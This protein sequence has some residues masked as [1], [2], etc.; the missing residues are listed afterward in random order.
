MKFL[1]SWLEKYIELSDLQDNDLAKIITTKSSEVEEI[2]LIDDYFGGKVLVGRIENS[3]KHPN[4]D[5]LTIFDVNLGGSKTVQIISAA[6]NVKDGL[7]V[8]VA[9]E[10]AVL[11]D[12]TIIKRNMRGEISEGMSCGKSELFQETGFSD[13]LWELNNLLSDRKEREYLGISI[14]KVFSDLFP[15]ETIFDI[16]VLPDRIGVIANHLGMALEINSCLADT[17]RLTEKAKRLTDSNFDIIKEV[18]RNISKEDYIQGEFKDSTGYSNSFWLFSLDLKQ[19]NPGDYHLPHDLKKD[20]FLLEMNLVGGLADLSNYLLRDMG[21]PSH[22]F[23]RRKLSHLAFGEHSD[24]SKEILPLKWNVQELQFS[25]T[26]EGLGQ[27]KKVE[28]P[29]GVRVLKNEKGQTLAVPAISGGKS[30][31][32]DSEDDR[33]VVEIAN[34]PAEEVA[35]NSFRLKYRSDGSKIWAGQVN[36]RQKLIFLLHLLEILGDEVSLKYIYFWF[37]P[38]VFGWTAQSD[39]PTEALELALNYN[40]RKIIEVDFEYIVQRLDNRGVDFWKPI[41]EEKLRLLGD[42][43]DGFL[44]LH[45]YY[46]LIQSQEDLLTELAKL[47]GYDTVFSHYLQFS[48]ERNLHEQYF[49]LFAL[50]SFCLEYG[51]NEIITRPFLSEKFLTKE[52]LDVA[53][54]LANAYRSQDVYLR[55]RLLPSLL[56]SLS[57]NIKL[58][59]KS[60]RIFELNKV[61]NSIPQ[62]GQSRDYTD[63]KEDNFLAL[64]LISNDPYEA[65]SVLN[66]LLARISKEKIQTTAL[67]N[68]QGKGY[69]FI[70]STIKGTLIQVSKKIKKLYDIPLDKLLWYIEVDLGSWNYQVRE[71]TAYFDESPFPSV[72]RNYSLYVPNLLLWAEV[73]KA[74]NQI[75]RKKSDTKI[76]VSPEERL[77]SEA[78]QDILNFKVEFINYQRTLASEE[79]S[80]WE[81]ELFNSLKQISDKIVWR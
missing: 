46:T 62:K 7:L 34:F 38:D 10:G 44:N 5:R 55:T 11:P 45:P 47:I 36:I 30:T 16:K 79:I 75:N 71:L 50:K 24:P 61:F 73:D 29:V 13:G 53:P 77:E 54:T 40:W 15:R 81:K 76:F 21:Q 6:P 25:E 65:T 32:V 22:F 37:N 4:A 57:E 48:T 28:L 63:I 35:R 69:E 14:C 56:K 52:S 58:G 70:T 3:K 60:P 20:M 68:E 51:F 27:L 9:L 59:H 66:S 19:N 42:Y 72:S 64:T 49:S 39:N 2:Q 26:F 78:G 41:L 18:T 31:K 23:S 8:P 74:I 67:E 17:N 43:K 12:F 1:R 33:L 80:A